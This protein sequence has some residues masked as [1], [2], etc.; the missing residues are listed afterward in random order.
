MVS[1]MKLKLALVALFALIPAERLYA[2][3]SCSDACNGPVGQL[4]C[5]SVGLGCPVG[6]GQCIICEI[7]DHC[8]PGGTCT[9]GQCVGLP[10]SPDAGTP[11]GDAGSPSDT[12]GS[13]D[14]AEVDEDAS[15]GG[16]ALQIRDASM[17]GDGGG[18]R[19]ATATSTVPTRTVG[20]GRTDRSG[21]MCNTA[22]ASTASLL[23]LSFGAALLI[24]RKRR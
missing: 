23:A 9:G 17:P 10:C 1:S 6:G 2:G 4:A 8:M 19:D 12:G 20:P 18:F 15:I 16:D 21:C 3:A 22:E 11:S 5:G 14:D 24:L 7:D 13:N